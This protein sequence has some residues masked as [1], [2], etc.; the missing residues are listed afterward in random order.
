ML[1]YIL[2]LRLPF[3]YV[4][5][6]CLVV[7][8]MCYVYSIWVMVTVPHSLMYVPFFQFS[9]VAGI[10]GIAGSYFLNGYNPPYSMRDILFVPLG[11]FI[12][13]I[14][15][16]APYKPWMTPAALG[17]LYFHGHWNEVRF[18]KL[19]QA[20][21][22]KDMH[23]VNS[24][25][26]EDSQNA[27]ANWRKAELYESKGMY[28]LALQHYRQAHAISPDA[29]NDNE[30]KIVEARVQNALLKVEVIRKVKAA[31]SPVTRMINSTKKAS[32][33]SFIFLA[34]LL[35]AKWECFFTVYSTWLFAFWCLRSDQEQFAGQVDT[36]GF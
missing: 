23:E 20:M 15:M 25:M 21:W 2:F 4:F 18:D 31:A 13:I 14:Q 33:I 26:R 36:V 22:E 17:A 6:F 34:P 32:V 5:P 10:L 27:A 12:P 3:K 16:L 35:Y 19:K 29:Y 30:F 7:Y 11:F 24:A 9:M 1:L 8:A 28:V